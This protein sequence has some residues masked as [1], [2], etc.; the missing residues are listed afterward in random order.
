MERGRK[1]KIRKDIEP[2]TRGDVVDAARTIGNDIASVLLAMGALALLAAVRTSKRGA[3]PIATVVLVFV[4][5][6]ALLPIRVDQDPWQIFRCDLFASR[7][8]GPFSRSPFDLLA[9]AAAILAIVIALTKVRGR[10][11]VIQIV[12]TVVAIGAAGGYMLSSEE[13]R[14]GNEGRCRWSGTH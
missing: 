1:A 13:S 3:H 7:M 2:R 14:G 8:L 12:R 10:S 9:S 6:A 5:R 11:M 4:A